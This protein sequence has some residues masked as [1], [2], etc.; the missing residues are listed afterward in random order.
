MAKLEDAKPKDSEFCISKSKEIDKKDL[1]YKPKGL[2]EHLST[3]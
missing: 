2:F 3:E 1:K